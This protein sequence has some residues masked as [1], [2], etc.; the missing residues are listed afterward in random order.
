MNGF[1]ELL[2]RGRPP[3]GVF[4][5]AG[6]PWVAEAIGC[7]GFDF[8]I[9]DGEHSPLGI[10]DIAHML[11]A[12]GNTPMAPMVRVPWNDMVIVKQLDAGA[13]S[14]LFPCGKCR[15]RPAAPWPRRAIRLTACAA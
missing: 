12:I 8:G 4:S 13:S 5:S 2:K 6:T 10:A 7:N 9:V 14:V 3:L 1:A 11:Q 15:K